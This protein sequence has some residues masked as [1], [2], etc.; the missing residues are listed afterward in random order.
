[1][2]LECALIVN[3]YLLGDIWIFGFGL[4]AVECL[5]S[6]LLNVNCVGHVTL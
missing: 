3:V 4:L 5:C 1:M 2:Q 6:D